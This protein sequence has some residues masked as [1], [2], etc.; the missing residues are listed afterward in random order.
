MINEYYPYIATQHNTIFFFESIGNQGQIVKAV[1][2]QMNKK[3]IW[4]L[5]FG[6]LG[7]DDSVDDKII[8]NNQDVFKVLGTIAKIVFTFIEAYPD[9][10]I[11]IVPV[12]EKRKILYN[13]VFQRHFEEIDKR[14]EVIGT[15]NACDE[16][17]SRGKIYDEFT[18]KFKN[19]SNGNDKF[20]T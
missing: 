14:F 13:R 3:G 18:L 5:G 20:S 12:D 16:L 19:I 4:N 2:F 10:I 11:S 15:I 8:S 7:D 17:Y 6:D 9:R 1:A